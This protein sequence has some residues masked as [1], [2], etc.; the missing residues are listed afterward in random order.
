MNSDLLVKAA[1]TGRTIAR[2]TPESAGWR[3]V[4]FEALW[5]AP[6]E[7]YA[8]SHRHAR[9]LHRGRRGS[10]D[11]W[12]AAISRGAD[13][14]S[15]RA[16]SRMSAPHAAYLPPGRDVRITGETDA[17]IALCTAPA[18]HGVAPRRIDP[19]AMRRSV[20]GHGLEHALRARYPAAGCARGGAA[21]RR[22]HHAA[23]S[24]VELSAAQARHRRRSGRELLE[25]TYY[26]RL[27]PPQGFAF[28]RVYTDDRSLDEAMTVEDRDVVM[29]P[30][31]LPSGD[32]PARLHLVLPQRDGGSAARLAFPQRSRARL[33]AGDAT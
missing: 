13:S 24:F 9:A 23:G 8:G 11:A 28:Q 29:V 2:V 7:T 14:A 22:G 20:R 16:R 1:R 12:R 5:L 3:Y 27:D 4:G 26:H 17:E 10:R 33:D 6:G 19:A 25:E 30:A 18:E 32:R 15:A 31:R 21:G